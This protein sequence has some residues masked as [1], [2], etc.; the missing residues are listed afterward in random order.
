[1][2]WLTRQIKRLRVRSNIR[3]YLLKGTDLFG[4]LLHRLVAWVPVFYSSAC[5]SFNLVDKTIIPCQL[6]SVD[7]LS[8]QFPLTLRYRGSYKELV[9]L[10]SLLWCLAK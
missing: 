1:M 7:G 3:D 9:T 8:D 4:M 10:A 6:T 2:D 5:D